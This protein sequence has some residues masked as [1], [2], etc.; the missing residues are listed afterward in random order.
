V[1]KRQ[2]RASS[3][4]SAGALMGFGLDLE[5]VRSKMGLI[6]RAMRRRHRFAA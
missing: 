6:L 4:A 5:R 3:R 2:A 1:I